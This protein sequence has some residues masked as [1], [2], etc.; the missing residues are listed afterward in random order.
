MIKNYFF[1]FLLTSTLA[2][3][4]KK[5][6][7]GINAGLTYSSIRGNEIADQHEYDFNFLLGGS[8][9][10][11][12]NEAF[13]VVG[14]VNY[15]RKT[16][17]FTY[18][19]TNFFEDFDPI[20][21]SELVKAKWRLEYLTIPLNIK[22][23]VGSQKRFFV[24]AGPYMGLFLRSQ[25]KIDGQSSSISTNGQFKFY[26]LGANLGIGTKFNVTQKHSMNVELRHNYGLTNI[27][28]VTVIGGNSIKTNSFNLIANWQ[29]N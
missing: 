8:V 26:D 9:E 17:S 16:S 12:L 15:E 24:N 22:Y 25:Y 2:F 13:S 21:S 6:V 27:S 3:A 1:L 14:N 10:L 5:P 28:D 18:R 20:A 23:Y 11:P 7:F 29:F 19:T 4:Q